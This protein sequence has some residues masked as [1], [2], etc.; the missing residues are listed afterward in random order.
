M[1]TARL[2][3]QCDPLRSAAAETL[4][5]VVAADDQVL[6]V[7]GAGANEH[8][9]VGIVGVPMIDRHP[10]EPSVEIAL[11]GGSRR[12]A[13]WAASSGDAVNRK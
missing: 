6:V 3:F 12:S 4:A 5:D 13:I 10:I 1:L 2:Q 8:M 7:V 9:D 11:C